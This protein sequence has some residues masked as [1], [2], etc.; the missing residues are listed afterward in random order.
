MALLR[1]EA[2]LPRRPAPAQPG[3]P[4]PGEHQ[5]LPDGCSGPAPAAAAADAGLE[6]GGRAPPRSGLPGLGGG[7]RRGILVFP[8]LTNLSSAWAFP[9]TQLSMALPPAPTLRP[10]IK[11]SPWCDYA[12]LTRLGLEPLPSTEQGEL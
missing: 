3:T 10:V 12:L 6:L 9:G 8:T 4:G 5:K 11:Q 7:W 1:A 2:G